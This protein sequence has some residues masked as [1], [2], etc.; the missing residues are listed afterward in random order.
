MGAHEAHTVVQSLKCLT[1]PPKPKMFKRRKIPK[2][3]GAHEAYTVVQSH[4]S[5][6]TELLH[7]SV[8]DASPTNV[9]KQPHSSFIPFS[10]PQSNTSS[11]TLI[12]N[13][14]FLNSPSLQLRE[15]PTRQ[16]HI[17]PI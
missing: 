10:S 1:E 11:I 16:T 14:T 6:E 5:S 17:S 8:L 2:T 15:E 3:M 7:K 12:D 9:E 4:L 13:P